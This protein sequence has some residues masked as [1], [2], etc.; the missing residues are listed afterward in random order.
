MRGDYVQPWDNI[1]GHSAVLRPGGMYVVD[2]AGGIVH[3]EDAVVLNTYM[4]CVNT[5]TH[6]HTHTHM[7]IYVH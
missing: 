4:T 1:R 7:Y 6:T 5:H 3:S 2:S